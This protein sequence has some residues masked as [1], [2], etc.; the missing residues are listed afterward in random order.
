MWLR[1]LSQRLVSGLGVVWIVGREVYAHGYS[2]GGKENQGRGSEFVCRA[3]TNPAVCL[4]QIP[5]SE[6]V[7]GLELWPYLG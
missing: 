7:E 1:V 3:F 6:N 4:R 2:S 5:K